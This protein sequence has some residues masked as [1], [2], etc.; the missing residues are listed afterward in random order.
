VCDPLR[1][2][3]SHRISAVGCEGRAQWLFRYTPSC[4]AFWMPGR[5]QQC[6]VANRARDLQGRN[7]AGTVGRRYACIRNHCGSTVI[8][9]V[10]SLGSCTAVATTSGR[11]QSDAITTSCYMPGVRS[12]LLHILIEGDTPC[13]SGSVKSNASSHSSPNAHPS[14]LVRFHR[15]PRQKKFDRFI[16]IHDANSRPFVWTAKADSILQKLAR[17]WQ[18]ISGTEH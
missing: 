6:T 7:F 5:L 15:R 13:D 18:R 17:H 1:P 10:V 4:E 12:I 8:P 3:S 9:S 16:R 11:L 14:W 2:V